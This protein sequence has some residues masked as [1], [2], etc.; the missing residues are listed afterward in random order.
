MDFIFNGW[1]TGGDADDCPG[2]SWKYQSFDTLYCHGHS[3]H[4]AALHTRKFSTG[5]NYAPAKTGAN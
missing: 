3:E 4:I 1:K 5:L 2:N